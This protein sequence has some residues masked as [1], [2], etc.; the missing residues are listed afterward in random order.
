MFSISTIYNVQDAQWTIKN[1]TEPE[2]TI[3]ATI[4]TRKIS[5]IRQPLRGTKSTSWN[6]AYLTAKKYAVQRDPIRHGGIM[7]TPLKD[8]VF[9]GGMKMPCLIC[10]V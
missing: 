3:W 4:Y 9:I 8:Q 2:V 1:N 10:I 6:K 7:H 5:I